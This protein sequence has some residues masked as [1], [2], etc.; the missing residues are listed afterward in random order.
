M[1]VQ[2]SYNYG[3]SKGMVG[4]LYDI[5]YHE[6]NTFITPGG[7]PFGYGVVNGTN[8]GVDVRLPDAESKAA[9][10]EGI[11]QNGFT[12]MQDMNGKAIPEKD[13]SIGVLRI[14]K[15][16]CAVG[17]AAK[18]AYDKPAYLIT[19]G[20]EAGRFTTEEDTATKILLPLRFI[21]EKDDDIAPIRVTGQI[22][23]EKEVSNS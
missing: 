5:T 1:G 23:V 17:A 10:F 21:D 12:T 15:I 14:G 16:W 19:D 9:D 18:P 2:T 8:L 20:D 4:G 11:V 22:I 6:T 7:I 13:Q 3:I